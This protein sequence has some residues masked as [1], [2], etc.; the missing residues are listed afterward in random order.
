MLSAV[1]REAAKSCGDTA[2]AD[3]EIMEEEL[4][5]EQIERA[6]AEHAAEAD[7]LIRQRSAEWIEHEQGESLVGLFEEAGD[8]NSGDG[9]DCC[10]VELAVGEETDTGGGGTDTAGEG[11]GFTS[12]PG[13]EEEGTDLSRYIELKRMERS[14]NLA[15]KM[16]VWERAYC[17]SRFAR[18]CSIPLLCEQA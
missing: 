17:H 1:S 3:L 14:K 11:G 9:A 5:Q 10:D 18:E 4:A 12:G 15:E 6:Q 16:G 8:E 2:D 7:R 13:G